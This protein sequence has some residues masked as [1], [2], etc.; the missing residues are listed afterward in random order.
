VVFWD[1]NGD[2]TADEAIALLGTPQNLVAA[3]DII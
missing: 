2:G 1:T 3:D